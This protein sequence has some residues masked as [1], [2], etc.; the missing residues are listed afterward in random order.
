MVREKHVSQSKLWFG[1]GSFWTVE[2]CDRE[3]YDLSG[4]E[5]QTILVS[6]FISAFGLTILKISPD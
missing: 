5:T 2:L 1:S 4:C 3:Q 6:R